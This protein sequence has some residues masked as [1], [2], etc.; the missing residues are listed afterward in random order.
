M[1]DKQHYQQINWN[2]RWHSASEN[3]N[4]V[5]S[6]ILRR[7]SILLLQI[8]TGSDEPFKKTFI[9]LLLQLYHLQ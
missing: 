8:T 6:L 7:P 1:Q 5:I 2:H 9:F 3:P 4:D